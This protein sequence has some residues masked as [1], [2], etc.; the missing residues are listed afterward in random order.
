MTVLNFLGR[1]MKWSDVLENDQSPSMARHVK[2][3]LP[4]GGFKSK[5]GGVSGERGRSF[6]TVL[7]RFDYVFRGTF[8][9]EVHYKRFTG[10]KKMTTTVSV[11]MELWGAAG[12]GLCMV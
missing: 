11:R 9:P 5:E 12:V 4:G 10:P 8:W 6:D 3:N 1:L 7:R 2:F